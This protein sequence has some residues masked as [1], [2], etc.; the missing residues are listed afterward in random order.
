MM[1]PPNRLSTFCPPFPFAPP[2]TS[3]HATCVSSKRRLKYLRLCS[4]PPSPHVPPS[5]SSSSSL[6]SPTPIPISAP[7]FSKSNEN[8]PKSQ[9]DT[10]RRHKLSLLLIDLVSHISTEFHHPLP[11]LLSSLL[12]EISHVA[13]TLHSGSIEFSS[14]DD[15]NKRPKQNEQSIQCHDPVAT[16]KSPT[17][18]VSNTNDHDDAGNDCENN[19]AALRATAR[20]LLWRLRKILYPLSPSPHLRAAVE[21]TRSACLHTQLSPDSA[22][23]L[24]SHAYVVQLSSDII[25]LKELQEL[26]RCERVLHNAVVFHHG[27]NWPEL[28][29]VAT[30]ATRL[31]LDD[32]RVRGKSRLA[33]AMTS[34]IAHISKLYP[35]HAEVM[36]AVDQLR[37]TLDETDRDARRPAGRA[38]L[39]RPRIS[40]IP[41]FSRVTD[42]VLRG[43]QPSPTGLQWLYDY[44]VTVV[45]DLRGSDRQN[46]WHSNSCRLVNFDDES[47]ARIDEISLSDC[48]KLHG[49]Q[50]CDENG[51]SFMNSEGKGR[52]C[53]CN[54]P[55]EDFGTPS[56]QQLD[57]FNSMV[58]SMQEKNGV[59]FV[60]CKAGIG[61]TG[62]IIACW[63]IFNGM[64]ADQALEKEALYSD[65]GG[66]LRQEN[67]VRQY[68][69]FKRGGMDEDE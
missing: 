45:V 29:T 8:L 18:L 61:R 20:T 16:S 36:A 58:N 69:A 50:M 1:A 62:T 55:I 25:L 37:C 4:S 46:Q 60:H 2:S 5:D 42:T 64:T 53:I 10:L 24:A 13:S 28:R 11:S 34:L 17:T 21:V 67:F 63:R 31:G 12:S 43:G 27:R 7:P 51:D 3:H 30:A 23:S 15:N 32:Y 38:M 6:P 26:R 56:L 54:I 35:V 33:D 19:D 41:N 39:L 44:G 47:M 49:Q 22:A 68:A 9:L 65:F 57:Q 66:G 14:E 52:L 40:D 48:N 59:V